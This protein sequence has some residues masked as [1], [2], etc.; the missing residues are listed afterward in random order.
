MTMRAALAEG[1]FMANFE[2]NADVVEATSYAPM[3]MRWL[4]DEVMPMNLIPCQIIFNSSDLF[5]APSYHVQRMFRDA[6]LDHTIEVEHSGT[7]AKAVASASP[8]VE[9]IINVSLKLI[10]YAAH[11]T[12]VQ[13][14]LTGFGD[15]VDGSVRVEIL[16]GKE[17]DTNDL[18]HPHVVEPRSTSPRH[19]DSARFE[20]AVP[21]WSLVAASWSTKSVGCGPLAPTECEP[22]CAAVLVARLRACAE[23]GGGAVELAAGDYALDGSS[24]TFAMTLANIRGVSLR[25][26][27]GA[28]PPTATLVLQGL[29]GGFHLQNTTALQFERIAIDTKRV[30]FTYG[31]V[32][33]VTNATMTMH[34]NQSLYTFPSEPGYRWL[35]TV[36]GV[37]EFDNERWTWAAGGLDIFEWGPTYPSLTLLAPG[38]LRVDGLGAAEGVQ[39]GRWYIVRH[40]CYGLPAFK[41]DGSAQTTLDQ[42]TLFSVPGM[43]VLATDAT[44]VTLQGVRIERREGRPLSIAADGSHFASCS[45]TITL[46]DCH[47]EG[48]G[49]DGLNIHGNFASVAQIDASR[50]EV[51]LAGGPAQEGFEVIP[52]ELYEFRDRRT[53]AV[54]ARATAA[55]GGGMRL[56]V[57][58]A[59]PAAI[60]VYSLVSNV[61]REPR[62]L[63][64]RSSFR[65]NRA[66]GILVK[67]SNV[68]IDSCVFEN[69]LG[70]AVQ[71]YPDGCFWFESG[72]FK[73]WT[74][75]NSTV[76]NANRD[77]SW[78]NDQINTSR[79]AVGDVLI[80]ACA[81]DWDGDRPDNCSG[82]SVQGRHLR[83]CGNP[84]ACEGCYPF[85]D[86][87]L[88]GNR[89][90]QSADGLPHPAVTVWGVDGLRLDDNQVTSPDGRGGQIVASNSRCSAT[91]NR[92]GA[93]HC[94]IEGGN[95]THARTLK[96]DDFEPRSSVAL[97]LWATLG[98]AAARC[99]TRPIGC[100]VDSPPPGWGGAVLKD[101][102]GLL[103][104]ASW[105]ACA[106]LCAAADST[107]DVAGVGGGN[108]FTCWCGRGSVLASA[109]V[110]DASACDE[111][112]NSER[113]QSC[114]GWRIVD[115]F[116]FNCSGPQ[117]SPRCLPPYPATQ[118][119]K[120]GSPLADTDA[121]NASGLTIEQR[122]DDLLPRLGTP[123]DLAPLLSHV[124][125][126]PVATGIGLYD[127]WSEALHGVASGC[128]VKD[129][130]F[131]C[132]T[133]FPSP[134]AMSSALNESLWRAVGDAIGTEARA[135]NNLEQTGLTFWAPTLNIL[136][137]ARV[138]RT[139]FLDLRAHAWC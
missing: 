42:V 32:T 55:S 60:G 43:G 77:P 66:R 98:S 105:E 122:L 53:W 56:R 39:V 46:R 18:G 115:A 94:A 29:L 35:E 63:I 1:M 129:K 109:K 106:E 40:Q 4:P 83:S 110:T 133:S 114:G 62:A 25:G 91:A 116:H 45:G 50:H 12:D 95:T 132:P 85:A 104:C 65:N 75:R 107:Y 92:C 30:P 64:E 54:L 59:L 108:V 100:F 130:A 2:E 128:F 70:P 68:L 48:Q 27:P 79:F 49:D 38:Q 16:T 82:A 72:A 81:V 88:A 24:S 101:M 125:V 36:Q 28:G 3:M 99:D 135:F 9:G 134:L 139:N 80:A 20:M 67:T 96:S 34:F 58:R 5:L 118:P 138:R 71:A 97:L 78:S 19:I 17:N 52:G 126:Q 14:K 127:W 41:I 90:L 84:V 120:H 21:Q 93:G 61:E 10:N 11:E 69:N 57:D 119:C 131:V 51:L 22:D 136:R 44:D 8:P 124:A 26:P 117:A 73:N 112:C 47:Y 121:C 102:Q 7:L 113:S 87:T 31:L 13:V 74:M 111:P 89:F 123:A 33:A 6:L 23:S 86:V 103:D 37:A 15:V 76:A 137:D